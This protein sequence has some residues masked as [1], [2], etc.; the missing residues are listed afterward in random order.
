[1]LKSLAIVFLFVALA[2]AAPKYR[3]R[4]LQAKTTP[5]DP[6]DGNGKLTVPVTIQNIDDGSHPIVKEVVDLIADASKSAAAAAF[7]PDATAK[8][9]VKFDEI[10]DKLPDAVAAKITEKFP[11]IGQFSI[12]KATANK[13]IDYASPEVVKDLSFGDF[14]KKIGKAVSTVSKAVGTVTG[15]LAPI[16][17]NIPVIGDI[18]NTVNAGAGIAGALADAATGDDDDADADAAPDAAPAPA[19]VPVP[20]PVPVAKPKKVVKSVPK[21]PKAWTKRSFFLFITFYLLL[22]F[23]SV[24]F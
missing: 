12:T 16:V 19:P 6:V 14:F 23:Y 4:L 13:L 15:A 2:S 9:K 18:V 7:P 17:G 10:S 24:D 22:Y 20:V 3:F 5:A 8:T 1:M 11:N 21:T